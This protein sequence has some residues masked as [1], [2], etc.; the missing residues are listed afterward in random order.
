MKKNLPPIVT[1][2]LFLLSSVKISGRFFQIFVAFSEK[3]DFTM[4]P[5]VELFSFVFLENLRHQRDISKLTDLYMVLSIYSSI[6][7]IESIYQLLRST[8]DLDYV[9]IFTLET[10]PTKS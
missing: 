9:C 4:V 5:Q 3:L 2:Q 1:K 8:K 7:L 6:N 10:L